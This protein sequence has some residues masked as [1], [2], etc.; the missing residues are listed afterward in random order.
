MAQHARRDG[1]EQNVGRTRPNS[2]AKARPTKRRV[3]KKK[4]ETSQTAA[5]NP[6]EQK[7]VA[8]NHAEQSMTLS[9]A[10]FRLTSDFSSRYSAERSNSSVPY[11]T[12]L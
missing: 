7:P 6:V 4:H 12:S 9:A 10:N 1:Q 3:S 11:D 2:A 8:Q 5:Q